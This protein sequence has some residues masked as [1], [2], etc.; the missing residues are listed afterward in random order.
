MATE[1][2]PIAN[3]AGYLADRSFVELSW[4]LFLQQLSRGAQGSNQS[5]QGY[6]YQQSQKVIKKVSIQREPEPELNKA[7][8]AWK[9]SKLEKNSSAK[10]TEEEKTEVGCFALCEI[11]SLTRVC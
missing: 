9:P 7:E 8:N 3:A 5:R 11:R 6:G 1:F 2:K 10:Q 4:Q